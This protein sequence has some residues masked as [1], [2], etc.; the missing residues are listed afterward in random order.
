MGLA[1]G[2]FLLELIPDIPLYAGVCTTWDFATPMFISVLTNAA[3]TNIKDIKDIKYINALPPLAPFMM[4]A[5]T[6]LKKL[7]EINGMLPD[8]FGLNLDARALFV[9][10]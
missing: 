10:Q 7:E 8:V 6:E 9:C 4:K 2:K 5:P 3:S 1:E